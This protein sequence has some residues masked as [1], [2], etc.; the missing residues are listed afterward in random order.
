MICRYK[1]LQSFAT[2]GSVLSEHRSRWCRVGGIRQHIL[3]MWFLNETTGFAGG[4]THPRRALAPGK[5]CQRRQTSVT[6]ELQPLRFYGSMFTRRRRHCERL[7]E[8]I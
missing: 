3:F 1:E 6:A 7:P 5:T 4:A 2:V 8:W